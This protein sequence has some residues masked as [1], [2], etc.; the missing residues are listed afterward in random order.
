[1]S[2]ATRMS[3]EAF[4]REVTN[5]TEWYEAA[6]CLRGIFAEARR[7]REN[8]KRLEKAL[9]ESQRIVLKEFADVLALSIKTVHGDEDY[10]NRSAVVTALLRIKDAAR[11]ALVPR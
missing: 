3:D 10:I 2:D 11:A 9:R 7:A 8:E 6:G 4:E 1:M 5:A